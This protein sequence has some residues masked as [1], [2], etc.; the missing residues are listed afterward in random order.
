MTTQKYI[1]RLKNDYSEDVKGE[2][3][4]DGM[5]VVFHD[6]ILNDLIIIKS[7]K[8]LEELTGYSLFRSVKKERIG[9]ID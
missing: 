5:Q 9:R 3:E 6:S 8:P 2:I 4:Q 1:V 7:E